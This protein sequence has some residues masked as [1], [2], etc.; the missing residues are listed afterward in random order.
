MRHRVRFGDMASATHSVRDIQHHSDMPVGID[1]DNACRF[2]RPA[3]PVGSTLED[4]LPIDRLHALERGQRY[5]GPVC[6]RLLCPTQQCARGPSL[7]GGDHTRSPPT[8]TESRARTTAI[9]AAVY[10]RIEP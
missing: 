9:I 8:G 3:N 2:Q 6:E 10:K 7:M 1:E 5:G 4:A